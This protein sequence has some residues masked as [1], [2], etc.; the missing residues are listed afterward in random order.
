MK[1]NLIKQIFR[2]YRLMNC[3]KKSRLSFEVLI[4][5]TRDELC[6]V[7][8]NLESKLTVK[9]KY[10]QAYSKLRISKRMQPYN[11]Y[12]FYGMTEFE[13]KLAEFLNK[14]EQINYYAGC[15]ELHKMFYK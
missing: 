12:N 13:S 2:L 1:L 4:C 9:Q 6:L 8:K 3:N 14:P 11:N 10:Y 7:I 15:R 5:K